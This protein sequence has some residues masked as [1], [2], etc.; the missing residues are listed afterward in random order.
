MIFGKPL[1]T[2]KT[3]RHFLE[4]RLAHP[5]GNPLSRNRKSLEARHRHLP[6]PL[7][8]R[9]P[10]RASWDAGSPKAWGSRSHREP[11]RRGRHRRCDRGEELRAGWHTLFVGHKGHA[12]AL[13]AHGTKPEY[14]RGSPGI[15]AD[16]HVHGEFEHP[17][18]PA[19]LNV[20]SGQRTSPAREVGPGGLNFRSQGIGTS[21]HSSRNVPRRDERTDDALSR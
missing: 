18:R 17:A 4:R 6:S 20:N 16:R 10:S 19:T 1:I 2:L 12:F 13:R 11:R 9:T 15:H 5:F 8:L 21:V 14:A 7:A 3:A